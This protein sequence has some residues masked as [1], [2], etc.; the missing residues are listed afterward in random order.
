MFSHEKYK[1]MH[2]FYEEHHVPCVE[3]K[4][5]IELE[6]TEYYTEKNLDD[7]TSMFMFIRACGQSRCTKYSLLIA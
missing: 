1:K 4:N 2:F 7:A 5:W 6:K 3:I